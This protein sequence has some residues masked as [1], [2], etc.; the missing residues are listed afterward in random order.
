MENA[1][2][3]TVSWVPSS[4]PSWV[5][6]ETFALQSSWSILSFDLCKSL[7]IIRGWSVTMPW[8]SARM[9]HMVDVLPCQLLLLLGLLRHMSKYIPRSLVAVIFLSFMF[10]VV[11]ILS[12]K[13]TVEVTFTIVVGR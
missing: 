10:V 5:D 7:A 8:Q 6:T 11:S 9:L 12:P 4:G 1:K 2:A 3:L 13:T